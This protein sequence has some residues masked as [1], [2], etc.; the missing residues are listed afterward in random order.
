MASLK[1]IRG[2]ISSVKNVRKITR[3]MEMISAARLRKAEQRIEHL[4]RIR[5]LQDETRGFTAFI[6]WSFAR[7]C[8]KYFTL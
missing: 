6:A 3:A 8:S 1:D 5:E 7:P 4:C 2:R